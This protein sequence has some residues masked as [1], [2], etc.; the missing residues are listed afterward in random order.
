MCWYSQKQPDYKVADK[1]I[2][3][4]KRFS[5]DYIVFIDNKLACLCSLV[6]GYLYAVNQLNKPIELEHY[7]NEAFYYIYKGYTSW[8]HAKHPSGVL[9]PATNMIKCVIPKGSTYAVNE[10]GEV[11]SSNIIVTD[12]IVY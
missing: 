5:Q 2:V 10:I 6:Y 12:E 3:V 9:L 4:Y 7:Y 8:L 1:D 11:V